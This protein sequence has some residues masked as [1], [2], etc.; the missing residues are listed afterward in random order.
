MRKFST[1]WLCCNNAQTNCS[2]CQNTSKFS[3]RKHCVPRLTSC[4]CKFASTHYNHMIPVPCLIAQGHQN[5]SCS[6][7]HKH[8]DKCCFF[9]LFSLFLNH[10]TFLT[11]CRI[12]LHNPLLFVRLAL[13]SYE[14]LSQ[15][16]QLS[17]SF[18]HLASYIVLEPG[19]LV[20]SN[21]SARKRIGRSL[22]QHSMRTRYP[23]EGCTF[24]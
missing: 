15:C 23:I 13:F 20:T 24:S 6:S 4:F 7:T 3:S 8:T 5:V 9:V 12:L 16:K 19:S 1:R 11:T 18:L 17:N 2:N 21:L 14:V 22:V 10:A